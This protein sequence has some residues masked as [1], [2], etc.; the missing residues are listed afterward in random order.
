VRARGAPVVRRQGRWQAERNH[1]GPRRA[2]GSDV[3]EAQWMPMIPMRM[4]LL[5]GRGPPIATTMQ[6]RSSQLASRA[7]CP[8]RR[9]S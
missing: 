2:K 7:P 9:M 8:H 5:E 1:L 6:G 3:H 4:P